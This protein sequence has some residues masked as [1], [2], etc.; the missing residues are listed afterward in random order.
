MPC[1]RSQQTPE[2]S[3]GFHGRHNFN[4]PTWILVKPPNVSFISSQ[5]Q[6]IL[7][8]QG[9]QQISLNLLYIFSFTSKCKPFPLWKFSLF[10][11][12]SMPGSLALKSSEGMSYQRYIFDITKPCKITEPQNCRGWKGLSEIIKSNL[13]GKAGSLQQVKK[14]IVHP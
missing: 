3:L 5:P 7:W 10:L 6:S 13:P 2:C 4:Q 9:T 8:H 14:K 1:L 12:C 11:L